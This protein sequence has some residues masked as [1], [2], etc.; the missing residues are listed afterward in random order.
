M[1]KNNPLLF[2]IML[3]F[4]GVISFCS[5][6]SSARSKEIKT[7]STNV[8][9][10]DTILVSKDFL[11]GKYSPA[12]DSNFVEVELNY[13]SIKG[14]Y[15]NKEAYQAF[16]KMYEAAKTDGIFLKIVSATRT[17]EQQK[18][19][20]E[21]KF[22]GSVL[23]Y[24]KNLATL[25]PNENERAKYILKY[26]SMPGT[27]RHHWG[28]DIDI[29]SVQ[30]SYFQTST[31]IKTYKWL[32]ENASK[33]GFCQPYTIQDSLRP[34]GYSEEKWHWSYLPL[35]SK[36]LIAYN[37][38]ISISDLQGFKGFETAKSLD[39]INKYVNCVNP[40]CK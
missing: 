9:K 29:N 2:V 13:A 30:N 6:D 11:L 34:T 38:K 22:T 28:T 12:K 18:K 31:G 33:Y 36:Y 14:F 20:W 5:C 3:G 25:Y 39:I 15:L 27:S 4:L 16:K 23:Y 7:D 21:G 1:F 37:S 17:F 8:S 10:P 26:S 24:G 35:S 19:I 40:S 32:S